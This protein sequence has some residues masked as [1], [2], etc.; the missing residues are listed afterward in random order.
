MMI[1]NDWMVLSFKVVFNVGLMVFVYDYK[2][3][4][5]P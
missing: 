5:I 2:G 4:L 1:A 3:I